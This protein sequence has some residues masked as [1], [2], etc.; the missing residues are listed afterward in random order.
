LVGPY[1]S[2]AKHGIGAKHKK[3]QPGATNYIG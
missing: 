1:R 3:I 2:L